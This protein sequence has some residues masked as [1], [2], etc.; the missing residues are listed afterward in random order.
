[1]SKL[2]ISGKQLRAI[3]YPEAPVISIAINVMEKNYKRH[4]EEDVLKILKGIF[5][6]PEEYLDDAVLGKIA[7]QLIE[8]PIKEAAEIPLNETGVHYNIFG[9]GNIE[10]GALKQMEIAVKLPVAIAGAL[11]PDAHQGY[12]L[13]IGG[14]LA[15][16]NAIIPYAVGVDI[17]CRMCMSIFA[18]ETSELMK[19]TSFFQRELLANTLFGAA[20]NSINSPNTKYLKEKN[21]MRL[22]LYQV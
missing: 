4:S 19:K 14:V 3:G 1:M 22:L 21:L 15:T 17:G 6:N 10:E 13:P 7:E 20:V 8:K 2:K 16:N 12:G 18:I 5:E 9:A 11:M